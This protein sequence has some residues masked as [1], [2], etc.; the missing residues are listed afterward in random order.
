MTRHRAR[1]PSRLRKLPRHALGGSRELLLEALAA[2][3]AQLGALASGLV[4]ASTPFIIVV[5]GGSPLA[6]PL[7]RALAGMANVSAGTTDLCQFGGKS[8]G[9]SAFWHFGLDSRA[10]R[11]SGSRCSNDRLHSQIRSCTL[12]VFVAT[13]LA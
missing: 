1:L 11:H 7:A 12:P 10:C 5:A 3:G 2:D 13:L 6:G 9:R 8:R 4:A